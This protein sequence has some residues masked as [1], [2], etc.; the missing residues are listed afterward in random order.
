MGLLLKKNISSGIVVFFVALPLCLGI[1]LAQNAPLLSGLV[2]GIIGG[3]VVGFL[4]ASQVSVSGPAAGLTVVVVGAISQLGGFQAFTLAVLLS[5]VMQIA[6][7]FLRLGLVSKFIPGSVIKGMLAA[8]GIIIVLKQVPHLLG[9]DSDYVGDMEFFQPDGRNTFTELWVMLRFLNP[10]AVLISAVSLAVILYWDKK[11]AQR[12][13]ALRNVPG[14]LIAVFVAVG[15]NLLAAK[16]DWLRDLSANHLVQIP[17]D[18]GWQNFATQ[19]SGLDFSLLIKK[20]EI[21]TIAL[22]IAVIGSIETL[23]SLEAADKLDKERRVSNK[24]RELF[25]Q[26]TGNILSGLLGG[27]PITAVIVRTVTNVNSGG[28]HRVSA[29]WHGVLIA[30]AVFVFPKVLNMIPLAVLATVLAI[31]GYKL[32][33]FHIFRDAYRS[34]REQFVPFA[35]TVVAV[36]FTDILIGVA[37]GGVF[38]VAFLLINDHKKGFY[39]SDRDGATVIELAEDI[40]FIH[41]PSLSE[42]FRRLPDGATVTLHAENPR[43]IHHDIAEL[44]REFRESAAIRGI[45]ILERNMPYIA[46]EGER[47]GKRS[48]TYKRLIHGN[49]NWVQKTLEQD[50]DYFTKLSRGQQP[51]ILWIGC[52]DSRVPPNEITDTKPGEIF[53]HRNIANLVVHTDLNMLSV[54]QYAIENLKVK[55]V[56]VAGHYECGGVHA[57]LQDI[58]LGLANNWLRNIKE[59]YQQHAEEL[60]AVKDAKAR[61]RLLVELSTMEQV[62]NLAKTSIVQHAW[63]K[64]QVEIHGWVVDIA[65]GLIKELPINLTQQA[66]LPP[67]FRYKI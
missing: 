66:D 38:S 5:G 33:S 16:V 10:T 27:L 18:I 2:S 3:I 44:I 23:L 36:V 11:I 56:I 58:D 26:G 25:A 21:W 46:S 6:F 22:T 40:N 42:A 37:I 8:I 65:T 14:S 64:R 9:Y 61:E 20:K 57:A 4:G 50:R 7:G 48:A 59:T 1:A 31:V 41:R 62:R 52:S 53:I 13:A 32:S 60:E 34:G 51:E 47:G 12:F 17:V 30:A 45:K 67:V 29:I 24:N 28:T 35:V 54:L 15:A 39:V 19:F 43:M 55:H 49:R 63:K